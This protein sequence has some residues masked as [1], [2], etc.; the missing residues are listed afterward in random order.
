MYEIAYKEILNVLLYTLIFNV[1]VFFTVW[2]T[3]HNPVFLDRYDNFLKR[4]LPRFLSIF[5]GITPINYLFQYL[6]SLYTILD[7]FSGIPKLDS[8]RIKRVVF[9]TRGE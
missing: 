3:S 2:G 4:D 7:D 9:L 6:Y 1:S 5:D 8:R